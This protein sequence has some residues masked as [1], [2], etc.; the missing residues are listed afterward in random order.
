MYST[1]GWSSRISLSGSGSR[2]EDRSSGGSTGS[3]L[4]SGSAGSGARL[5]RLRIG[6]L[7]APLRRAQCLRLLAGDLLGIRAPAALELEVL[8]DGVV[9]QSHLALKA[10]SALTV[11]FFP[12]R[13]AR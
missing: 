13:L 11:R 4:G 3:V 12:E 8:P 5:R 2:L 6:E 9:E 7:G 10:Y 1:V